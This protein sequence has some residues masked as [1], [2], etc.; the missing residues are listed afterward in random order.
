MTK[1]FLS[2]LYLQNMFNIN[3]SGAVVFLQRGIYLQSKQSSQQHAQLADGK[4]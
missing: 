2:Y 1:D 4:G 3:M